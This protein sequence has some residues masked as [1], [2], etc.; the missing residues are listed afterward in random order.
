MAAGCAFQSFLNGF[1]HLDVRYDVVHRGKC[2][3]LQLGV[4][5]TPLG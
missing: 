2:F 4:A 1:V 3:P 5:E